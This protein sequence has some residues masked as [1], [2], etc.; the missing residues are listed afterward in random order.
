MKPARNAP[1]ESLFS[2]AAALSL[3][4]FAPSAMADFIGD[5]KAR[6]EMRNLYL[7]REFRQDNAPQAKAEEWAQGFTARV[8]SGFTDGTFG[9]GLDAL[10]ELG[11][12]LDSSPDRRG[13]GLLPFGPQ[14]HEPDDDY[15]ELGL[16]GKLRVSKSLLKLGTL[17]PLLPVATYNDTRLLGSTF[18]GGLLTSQE[19]DGLTLNA[20]RLTCAIPPATTTSAT[21]PPVVITSTSAAAAMRSV[22]N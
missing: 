22:R 14:S 15:S 17:Q 19:I 6:I 4:L 2:L 1:C 13:T 3:P 7:N 18:E 5:S 10:G 16:T 11:I 20:G 21:P 12:K 9:F 8:E